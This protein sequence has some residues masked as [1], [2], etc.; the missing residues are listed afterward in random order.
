MFKSNSLTI[1]SA[2]LFLFAFLFR[3]QV[4]AEAEGNFLKKASTLDTYGVDP[5]QVKVCDKCCQL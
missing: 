1:W 4:P 2:D 5:H 3:G